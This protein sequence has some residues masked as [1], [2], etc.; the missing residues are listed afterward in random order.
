MVNKTTLLYTGK[1]KQVY[2]TDDPDV[3]WMAYTNQATALNGEKKDQIAHKGELNRAISTL[4]F[5]ELTAA[6]IPTHYLD[7]PDST[8]MI[9]K[10]AAML[11]LEVVVRN[12]ASGHFVTKFNVKPMMKLDPP[13]H[14]YYYKS[15]ELG[16]P[17]MNEAQIFAL[18]EATP[19]QLKQVHALTD[20]INTYLTQ[21]FAAIGITLVDFKLEYGT[22][23]DGTLVLAD[24]LSP[25]NFRLVDQQT[26]ASLD[27]DVFRQNRGPL[28][29]VYEE[30]LSRLQ[31]KGAAH[32]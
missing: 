32:V 17:F 24:E 27:K 13:I 14:E 31:E 19:E 1:A 23:K 2:A 26:G 22:L 25:D 4:L 7:S 9:V 3:L 29:P 15:D 18:H 20:R 30:V 6:G 28:T 11:P 5:K 12:Y 8:T 10:K 16:D 21:R